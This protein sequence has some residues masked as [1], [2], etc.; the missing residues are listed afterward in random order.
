MFERRDS[1]VGARVR[2]GGGA[3][4]KEL[5]FFKKSGTYKVEIGGRVHTKAQQQGVCVCGS[6]GGGDLRASRQGE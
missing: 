1:G 2:W 4:R 6:G 3:G 5:N